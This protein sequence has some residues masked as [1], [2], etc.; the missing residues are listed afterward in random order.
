MS[1]PEKLSFQ[2]PFSPLLCHFLN[3]PIIA[4]LYPIMS[5]SGHRYS[6]LHLESDYCTGN[7]DSSH[8]MFY[9]ESRYSEVNPDYLCC[10]YK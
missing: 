9:L 4:S 1:P 6:F 2:D 10:K 8:S 3:N 5:I 7:K